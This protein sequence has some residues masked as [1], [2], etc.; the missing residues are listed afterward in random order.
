MQF[1]SLSRTIMRSQLGKPAPD[2]HVIVSNKDKYQ[3]PLHPNIW[4]CL[5]SQHNRLG[6]LVHLPPTI[7]AWSAHSQRT[8]PYSSHLLFPSLPP[9]FLLL[10][11]FRL[12]AT[13]II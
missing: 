5:S 3:P 1:E 6:C 11:I 8:E 12:P 7:A 4:I 2:H 13:C 10:I 9:L